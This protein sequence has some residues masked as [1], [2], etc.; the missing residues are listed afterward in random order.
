MTSERKI[1]ANRENAKKSTGPRSEVGRAVSR[2]N[3][4]RHGLATGVGSD[5]AYRDD[6]EELAR[7]LSWDGGREEVGEFAR[8]AAEAHLELMRIRRFRVHLYERLRFL[9]DPSKESL[10]EELGKQLDRLQRYE[11]R[12]LSRRKRAMRL[13]DEID[14]YEVRHP[15]F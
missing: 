2:Y 7:L 13:I 1:A 9:S 14:Q 5:P 3:A 12:A 4:R 15:G 8:E 10:R 11:R 6:I